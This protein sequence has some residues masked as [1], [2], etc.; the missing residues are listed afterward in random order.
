MNLVAL[1]NHLWQ[2]TIF[3]AIAWLLIQVLQKNSA[4]V[5]YSIWLLASLKFLLPLS[6][7]ITLGSH[8]S[9]PSRP[10]ATPPNVPVV[11]FIGLPFG[12]HSLQRD[13][14]LTSSS[15]SASTPAPNQPTTEAL[16]AVWL[17]GFGA[18][19]VSS[20]FRV[21][22]VREILSTARRLDDGREIESLERAR[23]LRGL[24]RRIECATTE[25]VIEPGIHG[26]LR[27]ILILPSGIARQLEARQLD[28]IIDHELCHIRSYD[29]L[30][31]VI[32]M[33]VEALFWFHPLVW[34]IGTRLVD[35]RERACDEQVLENGGD[36]K[37]YASAILKVC[38]FYIASPLECVAGVSGGNLKKRIEEIMNH[39]IV[40]KLSGGK[41]LL[42]VATGVAALTVPIAFGVLNAPLVGA[43]SILLGSPGQ[44]RPAFKVASVKPT[45]QR[46]GPR[47]D[48]GRY[49]DA[50]SLLSF[51]VMAY[52]LN[53][54]AMR[55]TSGVDCPL[56]SGLPA[57]AK[58]P[59]N[60]TTD[61]FEIQAKLPDNP[62]VSS[63]YS[64]AQVRMG[65]V[66]QLDL[67]LQVLLEDR[68]HL[69]FHRET[70]EL[71]VYTLTV[72]RNGPKLKQTAAPHMV[73]GVDGA[74]VEQHGFAA[75]E[76]VLSPDGS[77]TGR[78]RI[79]FQGSSMQQ[80]AD[81]LTTYSDRS[82]LDHTGL[83]GE[84][85]LAIEYE[86]EQGAPNSGAGILANLFSGLTCSGMS[87]ALQNLGLKCESTKGP[88]EVLV[89]DHVEKP[90][91]N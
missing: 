79:T 91:E 24:T 56:I 55:A 38:E 41:K 54:C 37:V 46:H 80:V 63:S 20:L 82:V 23:S 53:S 49:S 65:D 44:P 85:D 48:A 64:A 84:Y 70:K 90:S 47:L 21:R 28:A 35:E 6:L 83:K 31:A 19:G 67:M 8:L 3:A 29:N 88:V 18:V 12:E 1:A 57:W 10:H 58:T 76:P 50:A 5:R 30:S 68:F 78:R 72:G 52:G 45:M 61:L 7:L 71:P 14:Q 22:R 77:S 33:G 60:A 11:E 40:R 69:K 34:W 26:I 87:S 74:S 13:S 15:G 9:W 2:S 62:P 42:L 25:S 51:V 16:L 89:I 27:P 17:V 39:C 43:Q 66:V 59:P 86:V 4:R 36:P 75:F 73:T 32:H 81:T